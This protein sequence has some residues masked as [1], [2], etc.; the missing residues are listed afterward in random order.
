MKTEMDF[1]Y[2]FMRCMF[3]YVYDFDWAGSVYMSV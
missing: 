2:T 1:A 3:L